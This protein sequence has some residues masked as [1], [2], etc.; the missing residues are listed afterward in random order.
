[1]DETGYFVEKDTFQNLHCQGGEVYAWVYITKGQGRL[2][3][4]LKANAGGNFKIKPIT[5]QHAKNPTSFGYLPLIFGYKPKIWVTTAIYKHLFANH[6]VL[7]VK[8]DLLQGIPD[9]RL[10]PW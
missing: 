3:L 2:I 4:L 9:L 8:G 1:M 6:F 10:C 7:S 5:T